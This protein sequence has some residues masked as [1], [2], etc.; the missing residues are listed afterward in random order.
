MGTGRHQR[1]LL[2]LGVVDQRSRREEEEEGE[3]GNSCVLDLNGLQDRSAPS[4]G[5]RQ[6]KWESCEEN[7][8]F[9]LAGAYSSRKQPPRP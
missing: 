3:E 7:T 5:R 6:G 4:D 2:G 9:L 8:K 1:G